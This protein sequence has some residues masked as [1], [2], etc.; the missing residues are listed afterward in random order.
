[1]R[2]YNDD[3]KDCCPPGADHLHLQLKK[4]QNATYQMQLNHGHT[5]GMNEPAC[6]ECTACRGQVCLTYTV[7]GSEVYTAQHTANSTAASI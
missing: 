6:G 7:Q 5:E 2:T 1:M 4:P 3:K